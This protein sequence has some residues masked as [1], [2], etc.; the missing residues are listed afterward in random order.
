[1]KEDNQFV[2][3]KLAEEYL[4]IVEKEIEDYEPLTERVEV[5]EVA[6]DNNEACSVYLMIDT[7]NNYPKIGIS[8]HPDYR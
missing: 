5:E 1:M 4:K 7:T 2:L 6:I 8:N 3:K